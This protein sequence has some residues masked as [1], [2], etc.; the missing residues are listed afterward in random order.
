MASSEIEQEAVT[1]IGIFRYQ[2]AEGE[3]EQFQ[4]IARHNECLIALEML[5]T[6]LYERA[7]PVRKAP[8][9]R[10]CALGARLK[11]DP[12]YLQALAKLV[13]KELNGP[14]VE[15]TK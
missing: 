6:Q 14:G 10:I 11:L 7:V 3:A 12:A 8:F 4:D 13:I 2:L 9:E 15:K 5:C 1:V